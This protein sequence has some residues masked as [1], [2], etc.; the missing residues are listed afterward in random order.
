[1]VVE[2]TASTWKVHHT[3]ALVEHTQAVMVWWGALAE[4]H[5]VLAVM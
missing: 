4:A 1:M 2:Q 3:G 5:V